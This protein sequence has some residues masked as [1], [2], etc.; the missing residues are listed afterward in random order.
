MMG[1]SADGS[2]W[3]NINNRCQGDAGKCRR[4]MPL[5]ANH[6]KHCPDC[7]TKVP[8]WEEMK[9]GPGGPPKRG[10]DRCCPKCGAGGAGDYCTECGTPMAK[11][12]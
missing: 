1:P 5:P 2:G 3:V 7:G 11:I 9:H 10:T 8:T 6:G 12:Q 4:R